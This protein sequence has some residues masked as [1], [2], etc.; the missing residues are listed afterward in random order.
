MLVKIIQIPSSVPKHPVLKSSVNVQESKTCNSSP[1]ILVIIMQMEETQPWRAVCFL[2]VGLDYPGPV[3]NGLFSLEISS[4]DLENVENHC[5]L[6]KEHK[7]GTDVL[8][9]KGALKL[10]KCEFPAIPL[11]GI[12][13]EEIAMVVHQAISCQRWRKRLSKYACAVSKKPSPTGL[14][15]M[16]QSCEAG[17]FPSPS[18]CSVQASAPT[19]R[20]QIPSSV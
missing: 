1:E 11:L 13:P 18:P 9:E 8:T 12:H 3:N 7:T 10:S 2:G 17:L 20:A 15:A 6:W 4:W 14:A 5:V 16:R 19:Q